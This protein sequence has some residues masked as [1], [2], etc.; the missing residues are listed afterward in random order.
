MSLLERTGAPLFNFSKDHSKD[1]S[2]YWSAAL[3]MEPPSHNTNAAAD[4]IPRR[5]PRSF[6]IGLWRQERSL[7]ATIAILLATALATI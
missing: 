6:H 2:P 1:H 4:M 5:I 3:A 7:S